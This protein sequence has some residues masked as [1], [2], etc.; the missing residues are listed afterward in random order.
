MPRAK[1]APRSTSGVRWKR[2]ALL[3]APAAIGASAI[4]GLTA[5]GALAASFAVSGQNYKISADKLTADGMVLYGDVDDALD[6]TKRPVG[7]AGFKKATLENLC[8][9]TVVPLPAG[10]MTIRLT[11]GGDGK[12]VEATNM[13]AD[14]DQ[15]SGDAEFNNI[16]IGI[17]A[18][19]QTKGPVSG[20]AGLG[21]LQ[22]DSATIT[23]PKLRAWAVASGT[24]KLTGLK[25]D[26][27]FGKKEC[28]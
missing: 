21:A 20:P 10:D 24:F 17:D 15:L 7:T 11:A 27:S 14:L 5:E 26:V 23:D 8:L 22:L 18:S 12:P 2:F 3:V 19:K 25:I 1:H 6:G 28:Y 13:I 9:S 4:V 16:Q